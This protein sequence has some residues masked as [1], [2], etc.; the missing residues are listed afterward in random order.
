MKD[1]GYPELT[2]Y[3]LSVLVRNDR[4]LRAVGPPRNRQEWGI[5]R[6]G[7]YLRAIGL[8]TIEEDGEAALWALLRGSVALLPRQ[9]EEALLR[10]VRLWASL[11]WLNDQDI[12]APIKPAKYREPAIERITGS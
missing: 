3:L 1:S 11:G 6:V 7:N 5:G 12:P 9:R 4:K 8:E 2:A 10:L